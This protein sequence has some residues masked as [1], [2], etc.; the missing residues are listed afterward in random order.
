MR[1]HNNQVIF[2]YI[3]NETEYTYSVKLHSKP[4]NLDKGVIRDFICSFIGKLCRKLHVINGSFMHRANLPSG[5]Y[6]KQDESKS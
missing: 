3:C 4:S 6:S 1:Y 2:D 5:M